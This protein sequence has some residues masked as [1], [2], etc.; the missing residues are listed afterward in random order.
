MLTNKKILGLLGLASRARKISFG[1]DSTLMEMQKNKVKLVI[2]ANDASDRT[3]RKF[4]E[5]GKVFN[6]SIIICGSVDELSKA[7][8]KNNKAIVGVKD[9]NIAGEIEKINRSDVNGEN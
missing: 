7:I 9:N 6:V 2:V 5:N 8:G 3:K 4:I 1:T